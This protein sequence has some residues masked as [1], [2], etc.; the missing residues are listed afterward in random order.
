MSGSEAGYGRL[1]RSEPVLLAAAMAF[2]RVNPQLH[3]NAVEPGVHSGYRARATA[4]PSLRFVTSCPLFTALP[5][6]SHARH[7]SEPRV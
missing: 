6:F 7:H 5:F 2:A 1:G 4:A 3:F